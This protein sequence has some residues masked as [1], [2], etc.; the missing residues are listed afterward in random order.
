[1]GNVEFKL[2]INNF[3][4]DPFLDKGI[5]SGLLFDG[6]EKRYL[7]KYNGKG[8][9]I[10]VEKNLNCIID[11]ER[12]TI[13]NFKFIVGALVINRFEKNGIIEECV[14][15]G[16]KRYM[17]HYDNNVIERWNETDLEFAI[18]DKTKLKKDGVYECVVHNDTKI[19]HTSPSNGEKLLINRLGL[20]NM[21]NKQIIIAFDE[22]E[23]TCL[24]LDILDTGKTSAD[25]IKLK[26]QVL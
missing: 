17:V 10:W 22:G 8:D 15:D 13:I 26:I 23:L 20:L 5:I 14:Y 24:L 4:T 18:D 25:P 2:G 9:G 19:Y 6:V 11:S 7:V 16:I 1:M 21:I 12:K 3:V